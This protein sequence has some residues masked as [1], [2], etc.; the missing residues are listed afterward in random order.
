M[1][2]TADLDQRKSEDRAMTLLHDEIERF[3]RELEA[4]RLDLTSQR[5]AEGIA[6]QRAADSVDESVLANER[7]LIVERLNREANCFT[8]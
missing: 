5:D 6:I 7:D 8:K 4:K 1:V 3:R 2:R